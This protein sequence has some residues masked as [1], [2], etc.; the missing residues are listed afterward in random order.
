MVVIVQT[1]AKV[2]V[3]ILGQIRRR[4]DEAAPEKI[5]HERIDLSVLGEF[6]KGGFQLDKAG[7]CQAGIVAE[8]R[9]C[10]YQSGKFGKSL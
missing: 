6:R 10:V 4:R 1:V 2:H 8:L 9:S 7:C 5:V 3:W